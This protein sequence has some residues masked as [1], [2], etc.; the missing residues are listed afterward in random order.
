MAFP[1]DTP[2]IFPWFIKV[3][4]NSPQDGPF[5]GFH[6]EKKLKFIELIWE[7]LKWC[8]VS[9]KTFQ[10]LVGKCVS[11]SLAVPAACLFTRE[12]SAAISM[13]M[14]TLKPV[15]VQGALRDEIVHW[16]F[17]DEWD[18]PLP[19]REERHLQVEL[20]KDASQTEWGGVI[21]TPVKQEISDYWS[22]KEMML[23]VTTREAFAMGTCLTC[24]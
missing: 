1:I 16:L 23:D 10:R 4:L 15:V 7:T 21:S 2:R 3:H 8:Y 17:L 20:V 18:D 24:F 5:S 19:W 6:Q 9:V 14:H 13:H 12:M 22:K 11:F